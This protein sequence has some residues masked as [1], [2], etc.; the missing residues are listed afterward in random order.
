MCAGWNLP[1]AVCEASRSRGRRGQPVPCRGAVQWPDRVGSSP[2]SAHSEPVAGQ[3]RRPQHTQTGHVSG[4]SENGVSYFTEKAERP[5]ADP[6]VT[7]GEALGGPRDAGFA[8]LGSAPRFLQPLRCGSSSTGFSGPPAGAPASPPPTA[9]VRP[10]HRRCGAPTAPAPGQGL[11]DTGRRARARAGQPVTPADRGPP[12]ARLG[13]DRASGR[14]RGP[15]ALPA[16]ALRLGPNE[17]EEAAFLPP[18]AGA[19]AYTREGAGLRGESQA[20]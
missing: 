14:G 1:G 15:P 19:G 4:G 12:R 18:G 6:R 13:S 11:G 16:S 9:G 3:S 8:F 20:T 17:L 10:S 7:P 2:A 5:L